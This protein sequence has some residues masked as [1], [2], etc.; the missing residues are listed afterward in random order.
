MLTTMCPLGLLPAA[1]SLLVWTALSLCNLLTTFI[2][3]NT[4]YFVPSHHGRY[5]VHSQELLPSHIHY[6]SSVMKQCAFLGG[7]PGDFSTAILLDTGCTQH[8]FRDKSLFKKLRIFTPDEVN[9]GGGISGIGTTILR[10]VGEGEIELKLYIQGQRHVLTL[11][12]ALYCPDL[13]CNLVSG[14]QLVNGGCKISLSRKGCQVLGP[15][16][17]IAAETFREAGLFLLHTWEDQ[18]LGMVAYSTSSNPARRRWH[19]RLGHIG[20][21]NLQKLAAISPGL[22]LDHIPDL[23]SCTCTSCIRGRMRDVSHREPLYDKKTTKPYET[24]FSDIKGPISQA[25]D[26]SRYFVTFLDAVTKESEVYFMKYKSEVPTCFR[27]Y[28]AHKERRGHKILRLHSDGGGEYGSHAFQLDLANDGIE[29]TFSMPYSQQQNGAAERLNQTLYDRAFPSMLWCHH[30]LPLSFWPESI[31][32]NNWLRNRLPVKSLETDSYEARTPYMLATGRPN[33]GP[34]YSRVFGCDVWYRPG[35]QKKFK[36]FQDEKGIPGHF[37][38][39]DSKHII[40]IRDKQSGKLVRAAVVHFQES[41]STA[42]ADTDGYRTKRRRVEEESGSDT[43]DKDDQSLRCIVWEGDQSQSPVPPHR[44]SRR[45]QRRLGKE[46]ARTRRQEQSLTPLRRSKRLV[47]SGG[48]HMPRRYQQP[49]LRAH[50]AIPF[51]SG[52][53]K[54]AKDSLF[55]MLSK[56]VATEPYEPTSWKEANT[57]E[58]AEQWKLACKDEIDS[59]LQ[60][61]TWKLVQPPATH[62]ILEGKWVYKYKRGADGS[63][64]RRK[65]RWVVKGYEQTSGVDYN[66]TFASV[67]K[68]MSYKALFAMAAALDFDIEQMDVKTA[69]LYGNVD[70]EIYVEQPEGFSDGTTRVCRLSKALYGLKQS[71]RIW[72][73]T[74]STFLIESGY[75]PLNSDQ[76]VFV[77]GNNYIAVYVDDLLLLGPNKAEIQR[78][79]DI[80]TIRFSMTDLGPIAFYL[81]IEVRRDRQNRRLKLSQRSYIEQG[82]KAHGLW[83]CAPQLTPMGTT[84]LVS[85]EGGYV[86][87]T[88]FKARYQ[89]AVGTLMYTMLG[90]RPDI[91]FA[92]SVVSRFSSNP[93]EHHWKAV[94][95]IF[96]Y[97]RGSIDLNLVYEGDLSDLVGHADANWAGDIDTRRSTTG[98][99]FN[100]G[101]GA[102]SWSSKRQPTVSLSTCEAEYQ[103]Q[104]AAAKEAVWLRSLLHELLTPENESPYAT[105]IY[106]DNQGA[107]AL[108]KDPKYHARTKHIDIQHHWIREKIAGGDIKLEYVHTSRQIAD[109]LTKPLPKDAFYAFRKAL[110]VRE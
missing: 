82:I 32:H 102:I 95:R 64:L 74:L 76:S 1:V 62:K 15:D 10:P 93:D 34:E 66:E 2:L 72:Y 77:R 105:I 12:R 109:G 83:D 58:D 52:A 108:A 40:R 78:V 79:K 99:V 21:E 25:Y 11:T 3:S 86:A 29:F 30:A 75:T 56:M 6:A 50:L 61:K 91:A 28:K 55:A 20:P 92:V 73:Q 17:C 4:R 53:A 71:P 90:T 54:N 85:A 59:L 81:G 88:E 89:S 37:L 110:G 19:E 33:S 39:F 26:G 5:R 18:L 107:I 98:F 44:Q 31:R 69:F 51:L 38:G 96:S 24:I 60:N 67:V 57:R 49:D 100:L 48:P 43:E 16:G 97:L 45:Y 103:A 46:Y 80:L 14:S 35:S 68:P 106:A 63:I 9:R 22:D 104:T 94:K 47:E 42:L 65:A 101:S 7:L 84:R 27:Q 87:S 8:I 36:T 70:E 41:Q 23:D 13:Q